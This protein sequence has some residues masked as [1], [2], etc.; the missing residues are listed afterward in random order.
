[1]P[2]KKQVIEIRGARVNN[3][4][5]VDVDIPRN[6]LVVITG[7]SG[8]G[9]SSLAFDTLFAEANRRYVES[10]SSYARNF[11]EGFDKPDVDAIHNLSPAISIDQKSV[12][13]SPRSTVGTMTEVYDYLR[14][15]FAKLGIPHCPTCGKELTRKSVREILDE[16][17]LLPNDT[18]LVFMA[19]SRILDSKTEREAL[20]T[21]NTWGYVRVLFRGELT[22]IAEAISKAS[23]T[24]TSLIA[25]V[26]DRLVL[27]LARPDKERILD[28]LQTAFRVGQGTLTLRVNG[29]GEE[30]IYN[31]EYR[32][33]EC[34]VSLPEFTPSRFSFNSPEGACVKCAGLGVTLEF[35]PELVIPNTSLSLSEGAI[36][37]WSKM[38][39]DRHT[40][41]G[42]MH[43]LR[44]ASR[45]HKFSLDVPVKKLSPKHFSLILHG[46]GCT[47]QDAFPGVIALLEKKYRETKSD[48]LRSDIEAYMLTKPCPVCFGKRLKAESLAVKIDG[49]SINDLVIQSTEKF[50]ITLKSLHEKLLRT[51]KRGIVDPLFR[52]METRM[53]AVEKVGLGYLE[54]SRGA[55]TLSGGE[56]QRIRLSVQMKSGLSGI[57]YVLD[58][59]SVGLHSRDTERLIYALEDLRSAN[60]SLVIVE[61]DVA[62]MRKADY[63]I[64]LGPGAGSE[65]GEIIF[66]GTPEK[67]MHSKMLTGEYLSGKRKI[68]EKK[69]TRKLGTDAITIYGA[70]EHNL[71]DVDVKIPLGMLVAVSG[72]SGS[73][74]SSLVHDILSR[75]LSK[76]FYRA[77][78]EPGAHKKIEGL[79]NIDKV[80]AV[81][82]DPIGRTPRSNAATYTG[83]F[84]L[85]R[86]LFAET[87]EAEREKYSASH[88]SFNMR[89]G[90]CEACQG[91]GLKKIEMYLLPDV[92]VPCEICQ[93]TRYNAK[94]L[95]IKYRGLSIAEVLQMTVTEARHFF[96]DQKMI[97]DK[98]CVLEEVGLGYLVLGQN[99]TNLSGGEAQRI[100]L[101]TELA[102][103]S[104]GKTLYILDEPTIG[105]HFEDV[106]RLLEVLEALVDKGN[107]V[108]VVEH[109]IDV[110]RSADWVLE[111]GPDGGA[112]GGELIFSGS[113]EKLKNCKRSFTAKYL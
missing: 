72:V 70:T 71:K 36:R 18:P 54:L 75:A 79:S 26:I 112:R 29:T 13:R 63:I 34:S 106:R 53:R 60:N 33:E 76:H 108:L 25:V 48:H 39:G 65:G 111:M 28:S 10:L 109:N 90:R 57:I 87:A 14:I 35:D 101:A 91:G 62:I 23:S 66:S 45:R 81:T 7:L 44:D 94:T 20:S 16:I 11:L 55:D 110:I 24:E 49:L 95:A 56:A 47:D 41:Q 104:T 107:S 40:G 92:Y 58:E 77:K 113:P 105:L 19:Q 22:P 5:N 99:A 42:P 85:I 3:L 8:S 38:N 51:E 82:Q 2:E 17:L 50:L 61:H 78:A 6:S 83:V 89:G 67:L 9:K 21:I 86:D 98:L 59:P 69:K 80:I 46:E 37:P 74:K 103:K 31:E 100:K 43:W 15:L 102:R 27:N 73:G 32:C 30:H 12:S 88:F 97:E 68:S 64:D 96:L 4:K 52:E 93:G 84:S 1:M